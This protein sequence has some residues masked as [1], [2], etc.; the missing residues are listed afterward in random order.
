[1]KNLD[2][3]DHLLCVV[4]PAVKFVVS[5]KT[6]VL[7]G[8]AASNTLDAALMPE[9]VMDAEQV[10]VADAQVAALANG[11]WCHI[12]GQKKVKPTILPSVPFYTFL[13]SICTEVG[14]LK[15]ISVSVRNLRVL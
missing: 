1:M 3:V 13:A 15:L 10:F 5:Q 8:L 11:A 2:I 6:R 9:A 7:K 4:A 12:C 14:I